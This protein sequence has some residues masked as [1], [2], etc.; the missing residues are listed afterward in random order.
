MGMK[1]YI[2]GALT[3]FCLA[4]ALM[5]A[6]SFAE[7]TGNADYQELQNLVDNN[8]QVTLEK[9]YTIDTRLCIDNQSPVTLDLNGHTIK[10]LN[11]NASASVIEL[12]PGKELIINDSS[13]AKTGKITGGTGTKISSFL[14]GGAIY[15]YYGAKLTINGGTI[16]GCGATLGGAI[17]AGAYTDTSNIHHP[18]G[19]ITMNG[20]SIVNCS[21]ASGGAVYVSAGGQFIMTGG[22]I[23]S[24]SVTNETAGV[25]ETGGK[26]TSFTISNKACV[27]GPV[28]IGGGGGSAYLYADG[29]TIT[30]NVYTENGGKVTRTPTGT[31]P[32]TYTTFG[33]SVSNAEDG[34]G[35]KVTFDSNGGS[36]VATQ[37]VFK[38]QAI[39]KPAP[40]PTNDGYY[41]TGWYTAD[42]K[43][44]DF[45]SKI[46][47]HT[48]LI[49]HYVQKDYTDLQEALN[50][51]GT[52]VLDRDYTVNENLVVSKSVTLDL[53]GHTIRYENPSK[54]SSVITVQSSATLTIKDSST[55]E[56]GSIT[57]GTGTENTGRYN[58]GGIYIAGGKLIMDGGI[59]T[60]CTASYGGGVYVN[61]GSFEMNGGTITNCRA[62]GDSTALY[63]GANTSFTL[64]GSAVVD[65][66]IKLNQASIMYANGG[67][68]KGN[69]IT[70][71]GGAIARS[72]STND[73]DTYTTFL[74]NDVSNISDSAKLTV[75]FNS[76][77][78]S[79]VATQHV[80]KGYITSKPA[81]P[82]WSCHTFKG[83]TKDGNSWSFDT[84]VA[85]NITLTAQWQEETSSHSF[86]AETIKSEALKTSGNCKTKAVY[87]YSC[88]YCG[89]VERND[90]HTFFGE[91]DADNHIDEQASWVTTSTT[92]K[93]VWLCCNQPVASSEGNHVWSDSECTICNYKCTHSYEWQSGEGEYWQQCEYCNA[94]TAKQTIPTVTINGAD[95]VCLTQDYSFTVTLPEGVSIESCKYD[96][97]NKGGTLTP[98]SGGN[99]YTLSSSEYSQSESTFTLSVQAKT[100]DDFTFSANKTVSLLSDHTGG[101]ATCITKA[102]CDVCGEEYGSVDSDNHKKPLTYVPENKPTTE[103]YG[104]IAYWKCED[105]GVCFANED[106]TKSI[107]LDDTI[108]EKLP[109]IIE[110]NGQTITQGQGAS[111]EFKSN[112]RYED[113]QRVEIDGAVLGEVNY[114]VKS[115]STIVTLKSEY[116]DTLS[117]GLHKINIV[118]ISGTASTTFTIAERS[119]NPS[120][121]GDSDNP[122]NSDNSG[123]SE[124]SSNQ[125]NSDAQKNTTD[126]KTTDG[127]PQTGDNAGLVGVLAGIACVLAGGVLFVLRVRKKVF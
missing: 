123:S 93:R 15:L 110:G 57:G 39:K 54:K 95:K 51:G 7:T 32:S 76:N 20:G 108:I 34:V 89:K 82:T 3:T 100:A 65:G 113:F 112:A 88:K 21:A 120:N 17:F 83:W 53:N 47:N 101:T 124:D 14:E 41:F 2:L 24:C 55:G 4:F 92:H 118:S 104:N 22:S 75:T 31:D 67:T 52:V 111:L 29:G 102:T 77:G 116:L 84:P 119:V 43:K 90:S 80:L 27:D 48:T 114:T 13:T 81:D 12:Q 66:T 28:T 62:A 64:A 25:V 98:Q 44:W 26:N 18:A 38:G 73:P 35:L 68:A 106:G 10:Y 99:S 74:G 49:A 6:L 78:G 63:V 61:S 36:A 94:E 71:G 1:K 9:D 79:E 33:G 11:E 117:V 121:P 97:T 127:T 42:N 45:S 115:G 103:D 122:G 126:G 105:C 40:D 30:G 109:K 46:A 72:A 69:V 85:E 58:G 96:F 23:S 70:T 60:G 5:P 107:D 56:T 37:V 91:I 59:I 16:E 86:T 8:K 87:Y 125:G 19:T 50:K